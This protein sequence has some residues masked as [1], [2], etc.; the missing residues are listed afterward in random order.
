MLLYLQENYFDNQSIFAIK[1]QGGTIMSK[2]VIVTDSTCD[3]SLEFMQEYGIRFLPL[4]VDMG[5]KA[6]KDKIEIDNATFY[7]A[8][9]DKSV[10]PKTAQVTPFSF[11]EVFKEELDKE[12]EVICITLSSALSG[13]NSAANIAKETLGSDKIHVIDSKSVSLG[14]GYFVKTAAEMIKAGSSA[15]EIK[16]HIDNLI[17]KQ[18]VI[19]AFDTMEM[20]KRGGR[21]SPAKAAIGGILGIKPMLTI[22]NGVLEPVGKAK[23]KKAAVKDMLKYLKDKNVDLDKEIMVAH[24]NDLEACESMVET[25]KSEFNLTDIT[26]SEI[27]PV[28]GTHAGPGAVGIFFMRK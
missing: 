20:L 24:S 16:K 27:G 2:V 28:V 14:E 19:I 4:T 1:S 5:T 9:K 21:I 12:N 11:E 26:T 13:T 25:L 3:L 18:D 8:I 15:A 7:E 10:M 6:Y 23:G 22:T 17:E